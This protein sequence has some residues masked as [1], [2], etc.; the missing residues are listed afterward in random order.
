MDDTVSVQ[1]KNICYN[2][3]RLMFDASGLQNPP[4]EHYTVQN[5]SLQQKQSFH[6]I[7][8]STSI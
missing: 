1:L 6:L 2:N 8:L 7:I 4:L 3:F 5:K